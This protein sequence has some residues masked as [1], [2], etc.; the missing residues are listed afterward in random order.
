[1]NTPPL[2]VYLDGTILTSAPA[3]GAS[4]FLNALLPRL[5]KIEGFK[6]ELIS[7]APLLGVETGEGMRIQASK[8]TGGNWFPQGKLRAFLG[9]TKRAVQTKINTSFR[10]ANEY[11][12]NFSTYYMPVPGQPNRKELAV[13]YDMIIEKFPEGVNPRYRE[14]F[15]QLKETCL[16]RATRFL[17]ISHQTKKDLC[18]LSGIAPERVDVAHLA[19]DVSLF[20]AD[21]EKQY[22]SQPYILYIGGRLNH[23]NF[24]RLLEAYATNPFKKDYKLKV[25]GYEWNAKELEL[26]KKLNIL[27]RM[28]LVVEP[29]FEELA[30]LFRQAT[31]FVYPSLYEGFG[32]PLL[33]S[34]A[35][36]SAVAASNAGSLPEIGADAAVYFNPLDPSDIA[37]KIETLL[38]TKTNKEF[39]KRGLEQAKQFS[40][41]KTVE[42]VAK[43]LRKTASSS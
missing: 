36:G 7:P 32:L 37:K 27:D 1:M 6:V 22:S 20:K 42:N 17:A 38:D 2:T 34:M 35:S 8:L 43:S 10:N 28:D 18:E 15:I 9:N 23:K 5:P 16:K 41:E 31:C 12:V 19:Y 21:Q 30:K 40:W 39:V 13:I 33:E 25:A 24:T 4:V 14:T 3:G 11:A 29:S 26:L